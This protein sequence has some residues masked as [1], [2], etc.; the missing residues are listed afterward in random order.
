MID[1]GADVLKVMINFAV[2]EMNNAES[3]ALKMGVSGFVAK[4]SF[5][6]KMRSTIQFDGQI[7]ASTVKIDDVTIELLLTAEL[8]RM[9][10]E[11]VI[12]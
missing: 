1:T 7:G 9:V 8:T 6:S 3:D 2:S 4:L 10:F 11:K 5:F 12:P